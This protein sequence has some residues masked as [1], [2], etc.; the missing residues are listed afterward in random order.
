[1]SADL[2]ER[3]MVK[4]SVVSAFKENPQSSVEDET[5]T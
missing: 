3:A 1:M 5:H 4:A 2:S